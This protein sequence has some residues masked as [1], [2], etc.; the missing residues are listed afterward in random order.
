MRL[1]KSVVVSASIML[2]A[3]SG[4]SGGNS[5]AASTAETTTTAAVPT[6]IAQSAVPVVPK[7][8]T[9][10]LQVNHP[11]GMV[12]RITGATFHDDHI[13]LK[14]TA[15]NGDDR[16]NQL[17]AYNTLLRDDQGVQY[18]LAP[19]TDNRSLSV[20][21]ATTVEFNLVFLGRISQ[22]ATSLTLATNDN[23]NN[24]NQYTD[25]P[26]IRLGPIPVQ[27]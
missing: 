17:A 24:D 23:V 6:S 18:R 5:N 22:K 14:L 16:A 15:T 1:T 8:Q 13:E 27:R 19:S 3:C 10:D 12:V 4:T 26:T 20:Q 11:N 25:T 9:L 7:P 2:G 21:P